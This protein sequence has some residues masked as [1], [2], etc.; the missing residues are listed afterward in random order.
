MCGR[1]YGFRMRAAL[2][3]P[4]VVCLAGSLHAGSAGPDLKQW[5]DGAN[6]GAWNLSSA[7][8]SNISTGLAPEPWVNAPTTP[9]ADVAI[10]DGPAST[11]QTI[12]INGTV[13][14]SGVY[15]GNSGTGGY[16]ING[17]TLEL[18]PLG[19]LSPTIQADRS[20]TIT[21]AVKLTDNALLFVEDGVTVSIGG[22]ITPTSTGGIVKDGNG[23]LNLTGTG[24]QLGA[25]TVQAG[26]LQIDGQADA[27][28]INVLGGEVTGSLTVATSQWDAASLYK[29]HVST[30]GGDPQSD[31]LQ[32]QSISGVMNI[33]AL[34]SFDT[35]QSW[36][37]T[38]ANVTDLGEFS[39]GSVA[40]E[41][42]LHGGTI[43][44]AVV[45]QQGGSSI[46]LSYNAVPEA[47]TAVL[48]TLAL[49]PIL[50]HRRRAR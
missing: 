48:G 43:I 7:N 24:S 50:A 10:F 15:F 26:T 29:P 41:Q 28:S 12:T 33:F 14:A 21:A 37:W 3:I 49:M 1:G 38:I 44:A 17:G 34:G 11:D 35:T 47:T 39:I 32:I 2:A 16:T 6:D 42:D 22:T 5:I 45:G 30:A 8:W 27:T 19:S 36:T 46:E 13:N 31:L 9:T 23:T 25:V 20:V 18:Q 40:A 4:A